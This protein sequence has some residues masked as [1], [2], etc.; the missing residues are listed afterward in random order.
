MLEVIPR[1]EILKESEVE[2]MT[3]VKA[4]LLSIVCAATA[5]ACFA[6][7]E[8]TGMSAFASGAIL[9]FSIWLYKYQRDHRIQVRAR[10]ERQS[11]AQTSL[12]AP[13]MR[14]LP[15]ITEAYVASLS[16]E[17]YGQLLANY[18]QLGTHPTTHDPFLVSQLD[19][20]AGT[21]ILGIQGSGLRPR[22]AG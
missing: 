11:I 8:M 3:K 16:R 6:T 17:Q 12:H 5:I 21:S 4:L 14:R 7:Q 22:H 13:S 2:A 1:P 20:Y 15:Y 10:L 9:F 18:R 19:R